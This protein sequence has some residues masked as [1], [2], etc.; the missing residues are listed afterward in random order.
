M[1]E[2]SGSPVISFA[3]KIPS[4]AIEPGSYVL[5]VKAFDSANKTVTRTMPIEVQ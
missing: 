5:Q 4:E 1:P 2:K 3:T